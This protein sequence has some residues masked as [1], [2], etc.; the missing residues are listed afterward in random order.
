MVEK[1]KT[2]ER[3]YGIDAL[4]LV[5]IFMVVIL[6][7]LGRGGILRSL[8]EGT[9]NYYVA[10]VLDIIVCGAVNVVALITGY[11]M[12]RNKVKM[13]WILQ[14]WL[15]VFFYNMLI[16]VLFDI[17]EPGSIGLKAWIKTAMPVMFNQFWFFSAFFALLLLIP[18]LNKLLRA[19]SVRQTVWLICVLIVLFSLL[20][21]VSPTDPF[22]LSNGY[23][24][25]WLIT[26]YIIGA[27]I[28]KYEFLPNIKKRWCALGYLI[29]LAVVWLS[30]IVMAHGTQFFLGRMAG[31]ELFMRLSSPLILALSICLLLL[32]RNMKIPKP[33]GKVFQGI[34]PLLFAVYII[35]MQ[36]QVYTKVL[37]GRFSDLAEGNPFVLLGTVLL[38][39]LVIFVACLVIEIVRTLLFRLLGIDKLT[40]KLGDWI[41]RKIDF[42]RDE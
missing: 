6:H 15:M 7:I 27:S 36:P 28:G 14:L 26:V 9:A 35:Y 31:R 23:S 24:L 33:V 17:F 12:I 19:L 22:A 1:E 25:L 8:V 29:C 41:D 4:K 11:L 20:S 42:D 16:T 3:Q 21:T 38:A 32:F 5:A 30:R 37:A 40:G 13:K 18:F 39:A 2:L 34:S 10:W